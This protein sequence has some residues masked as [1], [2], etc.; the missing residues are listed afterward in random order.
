MATTIWV[1][2]HFQTPRF[3]SMAGKASWRPLGLTAW[4]AGIWDFLKDD[5][6]KVYGVAPI[7]K[8]LAT[9]PNGKVVLLIGANATSGVTRLQVSTKAVADGE[10]LN[11]ASL[12]AETAQDITVPATARLRKDVTFPTSGSLGETLAAADLLIVEVFH[13]GLH[14]N[15]TLSVNTEMY[16]GFLQCDVG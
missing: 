9:T 1:P 11:P 4:D 8:D 13:N 15:D 16:E 6:A 7:P 2:I 10:S 12:T 5:D 3:T 14:A